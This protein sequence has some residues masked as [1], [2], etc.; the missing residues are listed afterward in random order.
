M[1][2]AIWYHLCNLKTVKNT[3]G[4]ML[5]LVKLQAEACNFTKINT[6]PWVFFT[7]FN[8]FKWYQIAQRTTYMFIKWRYFKSSAVVCWLWIKNINKHDSIIAHIMQ[9]LYFSKKREWN[10]AALLHRLFVQTALLMNVSY[11]VF[12]MLFVLPMFFNCFR[13]YL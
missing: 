5:I 7:F 8:L 13:Y 6:P 12:A 1:L 3:H 2:C 11:T 9:C 4:G 10:Y